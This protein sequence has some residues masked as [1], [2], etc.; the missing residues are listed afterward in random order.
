MKAHHLLIAA[1]GLLLAAC[2]KPEK[3]PAATAPSADAPAAAADETASAA[4]PEAFASEFMETLATHL[5]GPDGEPADPRD[6]RGAKRTLLYFSASW[7]GPCKAF[8][9]KLVEAYYTLR[10]AGI[11]VVLANRDKTKEDMVNYMTAFSHPWPG[12]APELQEDKTVD[13]AEFQ[14]EG[15]PSLALIEADGTLVK[16]GIAPKLLEEILGEIG[17]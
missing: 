3:Q 15:I 8:T 13:F 16:K 6:Y 14:E 7:C 11:Q 17:N 1:A 10:S 4:Q 2:S 12:I 9:P 5:V